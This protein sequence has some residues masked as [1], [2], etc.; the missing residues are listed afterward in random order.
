MNRERYIKLVLLSCASFAFLA[1][2]LIFIFI[3]KESMPALTKAGFGNLFL[4]TLWNPDAGKFGML[5]FLNGTILTTLGGLLIGAPLGVGTAI[6]LDQ[7]APQRMGTIIRRGVELLAGIPSVVIGWF[8]LIILVP[9]IARVTH[10]SGYGIAAASVVLAVM[11]LPIITALSVETL[12]SLPI[13]LKEASLAMGATRWQS[14]RTVL[15]PAAREGIL[16]AVILGMGRAI[17]ETMAVQMVI[18]NSRQLTF[19]LTKGT[20]TLTSR[21]VTDMGEA[22]GVFRSALFAQALVLLVLAMFL[23]IVIRIITRKKEA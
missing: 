3:F 12:R 20:G 22:T 21:I 10:S 14:I 4:S 6:F 15:L 17:G 13:E 8:G 1:I 16:V 23:I 18:G 9:A 19:S 11:I 7:M 2:L 5:A